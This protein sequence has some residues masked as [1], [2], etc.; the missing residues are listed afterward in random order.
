M[1]AARL[2]A[3]AGG[4]VNV[5]MYRQGLGD[6]FLLAFATADAERPCYVLIDCGV[7]LGTPNAVETMQGVARHIHDATGGRLDVLVV[8]HEH[9]DHVS[10]FHQARE[11]FAELEVGEVWAAWTEDPEDRLASRLRQGRRARLQVA[12]ASVARLR[13]LGLSDDA[14]AVSPLLGFFGELAADGKPSAVERAMGF[15]LGKGDRLRCLRPGE[16]PPT[17][18]RVSGARV[19]VLGPPRDEALL[20]SSDP[21][22]GEAYGLALGA[23]AQED[24]G[25]LVADPFDEDCRLEEPKAKK[26]AFFRKHYYGEPGEEGSLAW[27]RIDAD[28]LAAAN[29][30]ALKLDSDTNNTSLVLAFELSPGGKVLLFPGDAQAGNWRSWHTLALKDAEGRRLDAADLLGRTV[31]Y[32]VGHHG[33]HNATLRG[34]GLELMTDPDLVALIPV[35]EA[36][37]HRPKGGNPAGWDMPFGPLLSALVEK[38]RGRVIRADR[39]VPKKAP[40]KA[41]Q[42]DWKQLLARVTDD[43]PLCVDLEVEP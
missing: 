23:A 4:G 28:Y 38:T 8:T 25:P 42:G 17:L 21:R 39:K 26:R 36:M 24:E 40:A 27:R 34:Q 5:R 15:A 43:D 32:K 37:A 1:S 14:D 6:C 22:A 7:L 31:L 35:D 16:R 11:L 41:R 20:V 9:W 12:A 30:L 33:S 3:P 18:P 10:G 13:A 19:Y 2:K 29:E